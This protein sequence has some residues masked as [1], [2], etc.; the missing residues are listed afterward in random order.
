MLQKTKAIVI[1]SIKYADTS[2]IV[3][4]YTEYYGIKT[5]LLKGI[6]KSK[7]GNLKKAHF[8]ALTQLEIIAY[9]NDKG[10]LNSLK[11]VQILNF[12]QSMHTDVVKQSLVIFLSEVLNSVLREEE[13]NK[14]LY[15]FLE[16]SLIWLDTNDKVANFHLLFLLNLTKYLG[17]Y[18]ENNQQN[19]YFDLLEGKFIKNPISAYYIKT[20]Q[21]KHFKT[22]LGTNFDT[23]PT[24]LLTALQRQELL[25][26]LIQY[27]SLHLQTFKKPKSLEVLQ[28]LF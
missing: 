20:P 22:L 3:K 13:S 14:E 2:L 15:Q 28:K 16:T 8:Q 7:R 18:P 19:E 17:F 9:H 27:I 12:Y 25:E 24:M 10:N 11:E 5:Y 1:N 4:C 26:L 23:L 21:I 6:L